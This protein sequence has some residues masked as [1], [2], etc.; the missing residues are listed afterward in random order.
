MYAGNDETFYRIAPFEEMYAFI[1][2]APP[3]ELDECL[4]PSGYI[5][6]TPNSIA[7]IFDQNQNYNFD[8]SQSAYIIN[9]SLYNEIRKCPN[10]SCA[11]YE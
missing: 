10:T 6:S 7:N 4:G 9:F 5:C 8:S 1:R 11:L 3:T 2:E